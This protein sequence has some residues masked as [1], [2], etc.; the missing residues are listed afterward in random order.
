[1]DPEPDSG[2]SDGA[3]LDSDAESNP[4][5]GPRSVPDHSITV[6]SVT[7]EDSEEE[8]LLIKVSFQIYVIG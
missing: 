7:D 2:D 3:V 6:E 8:P 4:D 1:M 5:I